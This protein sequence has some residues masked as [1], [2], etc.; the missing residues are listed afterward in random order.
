MDAPSLAESVH[1]EAGI[2]APRPAECLHHGAGVRMDKF[3][4]LTQQEIKEEQG[5]KPIEEMSCDMA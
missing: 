1:H 5:H 4:K 2:I 3:R